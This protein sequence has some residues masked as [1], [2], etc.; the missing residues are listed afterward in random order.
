MY[1]EISQNSFQIPLENMDETSV[2]GTVLN[3][4]T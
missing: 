1:G 3:K 2:A 4:F